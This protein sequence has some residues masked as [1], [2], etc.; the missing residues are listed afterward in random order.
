MKKILAVFGFLTLL[1]CCEK[2]Q[3][4]DGEYKMLKAPDEAQITIGF[5]GSR[6]FGQSAINRYF[7]TFEKDGNHITFGPA[8]ATMMAGP[9]NLMKI[10]HEYLQN[11]AKVNSFSLKGKT[12]TLSGPN[13]I[14]FSFEKQK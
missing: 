2:N 8:G 7:G 9:E 13:N 10:E 1:A 5:E 4:L 14:S 6:Y 3:S 12:L 11:L